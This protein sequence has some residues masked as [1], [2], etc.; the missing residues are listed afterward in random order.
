MATVIKYK[1]CVWCQQRRWTQPP[2]WPNC[3]VTTVCT[4]SPGAPDKAQHLTAITRGVACQAAWSCLPQPAGPE[5]IQQVC[6]ISGSLQWVREQSLIT[7]S[8]VNATQNEKDWKRCDMNFICCLI[9]LIFHNRVVSRQV[10]A[11]HSHGTAWGTRSNPQRQETHSLMITY[12]G[13]ASR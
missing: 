8:D 13:Y 12:H 1:C 9:S 11:L 10:A 5:K 3:T 6:L 7:G 2:T 4:S